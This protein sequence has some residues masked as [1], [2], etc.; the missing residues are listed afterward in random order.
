MT[1]RIES[2]NQRRH[3]IDEEH[4]LEAEARQLA[5]LPGKTDPAGLER[6]LEQRRRVEAIDMVAPQQRGVDGQE[7][8][9]GHPPEIRI[10]W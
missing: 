7:N 9:R 10:L 8:G 2:E 5:E 4:G 1:D 3:R 6:T